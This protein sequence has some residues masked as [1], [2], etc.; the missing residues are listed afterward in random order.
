MIALAKYCQVSTHVPVFAVF[1]PFFAS[2]CIGQS[3]ISNVR[4]REVQQH[5]GKGCPPG[6]ASNRANLS[7]VPVFE[8]YSNGFYIQQLINHRFSV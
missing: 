8:R 1:S 3:D 4:V 6:K 5:R 2:F 7:S